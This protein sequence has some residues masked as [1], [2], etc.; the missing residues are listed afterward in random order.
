MEGFLKLINKI[1]DYTGIG[2]AYLLIPMIL[3]IV[4]SVIVRYFFHDIVHWA[5]EISLFLYGI[6]YMVGGAYTLKEQAHVRVDILPGRL[7][8]KWNCYIDIFSYFT[9]LF[10]CSLFVYLG[11]KFA[12]ISTLQLERSIMQTPFDPPI[13]WYKWF[14]PFSAA[15]LGLQALV[16]TIKTYRS[17]N[18]K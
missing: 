7:S 4:Y 9:I 3:T 13:W 17:L 1:S 12:W 11:T 18:S 15:I 10:V 2:S 5:F 6:F 14:I 8:H 16:E